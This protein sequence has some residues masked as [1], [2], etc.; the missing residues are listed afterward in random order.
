MFCHQMRSGL[1]CR[2]MSYF[3]N[4]DFQSVL[5]FEMVDEELWTRV[6]L[7]Q[8]TEDSLRFSEPSFSFRQP[9]LVQ[10]LIWNHACDGTLLS[11][12]AEKCF[13]IVNTSKQCFPSEQ[14]EKMLFTSSLCCPFPP[15]PHIPFFGGEMSPV[16]VSI[17]NKGVPFALRPSP[18][19]WGFAARISDCGYFRWDLLSVLPR[20]SIAWLERGGCCSS[21]NSPFWICT[22]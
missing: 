19:L 22:R 10:W 9:P 6:C 1:F 13:W 7:Q 8:R 20:I 4:S 14:K 2:Q 16:D 21:H 3:K 5:D 11:S 12:G 18:V 15:P 17:Y